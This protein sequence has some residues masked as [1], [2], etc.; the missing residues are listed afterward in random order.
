MTIGGRRTDLPS[1]RSR[2]GVGAQFAVTLFAAVALL[3]AVALLA[4]ASQLVA[5]AAGPA[6]SAFVSVAPQA[7]FVERVGGPHV[8]VEVLVAPGQSPHA[9]EPTPKQMA[10]LAGSD[11]YFAIG[12]PFEAR[13]LPRITALDGGLL[14]VDTAA[15]VERRSIDGAA[16]PREHDGAHDEARDG[17]DDPHVWL[18]PGNVALIARS[19]AHALAEIDP[20][21][22][23]DY[24]ANLEDFLRELADLD[25]ELT[26]ALA[27][28]EGRPLYVFHPAFGYFADAYGLEQVA[29]ETG[30]REPSARE[31]AELI[32]R[33]SA[34]GARVV[35]VQPQFSTRSAEA[36]ADE[37][38]GV[39]VPLDPLA[40]DYVENL[41]AMAAS[42][43]R[44]LDVADD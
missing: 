21:R 39:V 13:L 1:R 4:G 44:A 5:A 24:E 25:A 20:P 31:L 9:F 38:G 6:V 34:D 42:V 12:L 30:G 22:A 18:D 23:R 36:I 16:P 15:D 2:I 19:I 33:A 10:S 3:E 28:L 8:A 40:A 26:K 35:F 14:V 11:V 29:V 7:A 43:R 17:L 27:P 32:E 41:R 37:I